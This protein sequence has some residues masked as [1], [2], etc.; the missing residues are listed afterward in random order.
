M[1]D[2]PMPRGRYAL[3]VSAVLV[4]AV[5]VLAAVAQLLGSP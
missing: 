4:I 3:A 5:P 1:S 2:I